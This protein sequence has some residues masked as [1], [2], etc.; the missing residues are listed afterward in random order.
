[1][2]SRHTPIA[3]VGGGP[4]GLALGL[5]LSK[6][7]IPCVVFEK[8]PGLSTHPKAMGISRRSAEI[9]RQLGILKALYEPCR[10]LTE[11]PEVCLNIFARSFIGE[12]WGRIP[13]TER[14]SPLSP[15]PF[16]HCPQTLIEQVILGAL[17]KWH[18]VVFIL[19]RK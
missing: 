9:F 19:I 10:H 12:E 18:L 17:E 6:R 4:S 3:I 2:S 1:M 5:Q 16:F 7:K 13:S 14:L 8:K 11:D 15:G